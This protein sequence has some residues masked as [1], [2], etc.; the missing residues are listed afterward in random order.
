MIFLSIAQTVETLCKK[1]DTRDPFEITRQLNIMLELEPLGTVRGYYA[2]S[3]R[4]RV[5]HINENLYEE[6]QLFTC[7]HELGH[8]IMHPNLNTLFL[9]SSTYFSVNKLESEADRFAI[10]MLYTDEYLKDFGEC[11][12]N[13]IAS[14]LNLPEQLVEYRLKSIK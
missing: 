4:Q 11:T 1:Y 6:Q 5:I 10:Q 14:C 3:F 8:A 2:F 12:I 9:K 13:Q 7:A